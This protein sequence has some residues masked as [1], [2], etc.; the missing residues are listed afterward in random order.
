MRRAVG[1]GALLAVALLV[2]CA[3]AGSTA[4]DPGDGALSGDLVLFAAA[5][6]TGTFTEIGDLFMAEHP[7]VTVTFGFGGSSGLA[8]QIVSGAPADVFAAASP[9]T[10]QT[11]VDAGVA[12]TDPQTFVTNTLQIVVPAGNPAN[13]T[14]LADFTDESRKI[15]LCAPEVP[16][17]AA[18]AEVFDAAG[19][20]P[21]PDTLE[22][23]VKAVLTKVRLDEAD[24][25]LVYRTDVIA[26]GDA[27]EPIELPEAGSAVNDYPI[28]LLTGSPNPDV[29]TVFIAF[30]LAEGQ[31]VLSAAGFGAP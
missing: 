10:M 1:S 30:V 4:P 31:A 3:P 26:A 12:A 17:G 18:S 13:V 7:D 16:C 27:V 23:D 20:T 8:Q 29:A 2:G 15:A 22:R 11:V 19:L 9:A 14:G 21:A 28:A 24:A 25:G 5:S 6:L